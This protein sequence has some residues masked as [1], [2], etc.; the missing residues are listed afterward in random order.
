MPLVSYDWLISLYTLFAGAAP[1]FLAA[2]AGDQTIAKLGT[3]WNLEPN[4]CGYCRKQ[5][6]HNFGIKH[7]RTLA[8]SIAVAAP[9]KTTAGTGSLVRRGCFLR[10]S[11]EDKS[12]R[13]ILV[14]AVKITRGSK[15]SRA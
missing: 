2:R 8:F 15:V 13:K 3:G 4:V 9:P 1:S 10:C 14:M 5:R 11:I 7:S 12:E 6:L